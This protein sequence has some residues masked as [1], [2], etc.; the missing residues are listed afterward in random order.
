MATTPIQYPLINGIR[1]SI[2]SVELK[3]NGQI[4]IGFKSINYE[5]SLEPGMVRGNHPDPVGDTLGVAEYSADAEVYLAEYNQLLQALGPGFATIHF[6][7]IVTYSENG[8]D[9]I[10]DELIGCRIKKGTASQSQGSDPLVRKIEF[11]VLK[12]KPNG[13]DLLSVP[14]KGVQT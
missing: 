12:I 10:V 2:A 5:W 6:P 9:T 4:Y 8:F 7:I 14:L 1:H 13:V 3:F 11:S